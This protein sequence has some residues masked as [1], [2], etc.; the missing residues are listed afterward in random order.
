MW[1]HIF[2][3]PALEVFLSTATFVQNL[4]VSFR[5][6][7]KETSHGCLQASAD[8]TL[9]FIPLKNVLS[10]DNCSV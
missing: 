3:L 6:L 10:F 9:R 8:N 2:T 5:M 7:G 1:K 4:T